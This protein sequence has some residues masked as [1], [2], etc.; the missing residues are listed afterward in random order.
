MSHFSYLASAEF[1]ATFVSGAPR[2]PY[3]AVSLPEQRRVICMRASASVLQG[4]R[5]LTG[6]N[7]FPTESS[8]R[9]AC[10]LSGH[11]SLPVRSRPSLS[12]EDT[13]EGEPMDAVTN[14]WQTIG[15]APADVFNEEFFGT[16][17]KR[18]RFIFW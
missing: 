5:C 1:E 9:D 7:R 3:F 2:F 13:S 16:T 17:T 8:C 6:S 14:G 18:A 11:R 10:A 4:H 12:S 15:D